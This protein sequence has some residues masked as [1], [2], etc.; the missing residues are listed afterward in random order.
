MTDQDYLRLVAACEAV[1]ELAVAVDVPEAECNAAEGMAFADGYAEIVDR[2]IAAKRDYFNALRQPW[3]DEQDELEKAKFVRQS[4]KRVD[5]L[6]KTMEEAQR[7]LETFKRIDRAEAELIQAREELGSRENTCRTSYT[8]RQLLEA[9]AA[10]EAAQGRHDFFYTKYW[11][12][13]GDRQAGIKEKSKP[14]NVIDGVLYVRSGFKTIDG[15]RRELWE[16]V[17]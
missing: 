5:R 7:H 15:E 3:L 16:K 12:A 14:T 6:A 11:H 17:V 4:I 8:V 9:E 2:L 10:E 13:F 1:G